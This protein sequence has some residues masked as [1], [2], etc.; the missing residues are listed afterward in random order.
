MNH[1]PSRVPD[2]R[3]I[4]VRALV[5]LLLAAPNAAFA[6]P[7]ANEMSSYRGLHPLS[8]HMGEFCYIDVP[9]VHSEAPPDTRVYV[10]VEGRDN[11]FVGDPVA[12]GYDG[13]RFTYFGPHLLVDPSLPPNHRFYCYLKGPHYHAYAP[14]PGPTSGFVEKDGVYWYV[15]PEAPEFE[16]DRLRQ[17]V[18]DVHPIAGY[19]AAKVDLAAAPPG[20]PSLGKT[21]AAGAS[22]STPAQVRPGVRAVGPTNAKGVGSGKAAKTLAPVKGAA[23][24]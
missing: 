17:W 12:L 9:H 15:A 7:N 14:P 20:Y 19:I 6:A 1:A 10:V 24:P 21:A 2:L 5:A 11:L 23:S 4:A 3:R 16:R 18:N 8:P 13:P 22:P